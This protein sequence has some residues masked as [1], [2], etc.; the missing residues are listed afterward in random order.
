MPRRLVSSTSFRG[1]TCADDTTWYRASL[2]AFSKSSPRGSWPHALKRK[3]SGII[4][5]LALSFFRLGS[6]LLLQ[7]STLAANSF[8][9]APLP[10]AALYEP[11]TSPNIRSNRSRSSYRLDLSASSM[12]A[13]TAIQAS[14]LALCWN[15]PRIVRSAIARDV[16]IPPS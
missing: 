6:L 10:Q 5:S 7:A 9:T 12:L 2:D 11:R 4:V 13:F 16:I 15:V 1:L 14:P 8:N 3:Q